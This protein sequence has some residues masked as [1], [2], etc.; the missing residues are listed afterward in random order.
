MI[1]QHAA[2]PLWTVLA[3]HHPVAVIA[4]TGPD[5]AW[6]IVSALD[7]H[8]DLPSSRQ[9]IRIVPSSPALREQ[10]LSRAVQ[11]G[12]ADQFLACVRGGMFLTY[13]D[14]VSPRTGSCFQ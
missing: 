8:E 3:D 1:A 4:A 7:A 6:K 5:D 14:G 9:D 12:C 11:L 10:T 13:I 2:K